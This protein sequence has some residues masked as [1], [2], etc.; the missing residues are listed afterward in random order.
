[1]KLPEVIGRNKV[2]DGKI[3]LLYAQDS[4]P[5]SKI[6]SK[7]GITGSR[8]QQ[9]LYDNKHLLSINKTWEQIKQKNRIQ[10]HINRKTD[11][12]RDVLEWEELMRKTISDDTPLVDNSQHTH[13][14]INDNAYIDSL[15]KRGVAIP[16]SIERRL[17]ATS[18]V[19]PD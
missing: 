11:S 9:I 10:S 17:R 7:F 6:G 8:I 5:M 4:L 2:R 18:V 12:K 15:R 1:M 13:V 3:L 19:K 14:N 16:E